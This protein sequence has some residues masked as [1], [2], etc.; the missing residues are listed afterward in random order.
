VVRVYTHVYESPAGPLFAAVDRSGSVLRLS[1][2]DITAEFLPGESE[3]NKYACGE[4]EYQLDQYF[5][6]ERRSFSLA[7]TLQGTEFQNTVW[8]RLRKINFGETITYGTLAQKVGRKNAAQA[9]GNAVAANP[10]V[11][12][13][14]CHRVV[15]ATGGLGFYARKYLDEERGREIKGT[16]LEIEGAKQAAP[17]VPPG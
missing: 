16:L 3:R 5:R 11:L 15:P 9:V 10:V 8:N 2:A 12:L 14:P 13:V 4:L 17:A 7:V 6:N 1:W